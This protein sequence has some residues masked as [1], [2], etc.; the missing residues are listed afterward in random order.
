MLELQIFKQSVSKLLLSPERL[1]KIEVLETLITFSE[2]QLKSIL[3]CFL[4][5]E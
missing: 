4:I 1:F 3:N 5:A 2:L